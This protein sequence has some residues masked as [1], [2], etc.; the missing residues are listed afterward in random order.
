MQLNYRYCGTADGIEACSQTTVKY[1]IRNFDAYY[2]G[3]DLLKYPINTPRTCYF[4][5][6]MT[7]LSTV[8]QHDCTY[9]CNDIHTCHPIV[10]RT[11]GQFRHKVP[12][13]NLIVGHGSVARMPIDGDTFV[14]LTENVRSAFGEM[15]LHR[16]ILVLIGIR[17]V[18]HIEFHVHR[19]WRFDPI[20]KDQRTI[21]QF[22]FL[23]EF[24]II[25]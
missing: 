10:Q 11:I 24:G 17:P 23:Y 4:T 6:S 25:I 20:G 16:V 2:V 22:E 8:I 14:M 3:C 7:G 19:Q 21:A 18:E 12:R 5:Q 9:R 1:K 15:R 13:S